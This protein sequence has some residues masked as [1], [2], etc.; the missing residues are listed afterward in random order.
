MPY[1]PA[2]WPQDG[3]FEGAALNRPQGLAF[4]PR[5][6]VLYVADTENHAVG[7]LYVL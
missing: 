7:A 6:G 5:H 2:L 4:S 3:S 1:P